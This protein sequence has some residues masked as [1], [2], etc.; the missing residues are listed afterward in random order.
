M[1]VFRES[2]KAKAAAGEVPAW[3]IKSRKDRAAEALQKPMRSVDIIIARMNGGKK[4]IL[5]GKLDE[6]WCNNGK[7]EWGVPG[8][9]IRGKEKWKTTVVRDILDDLGCEVVMCRKFCQNENHALGNHYVGIGVIA[10]ISGEPRVMVPQDWKE[11]KWFPVDAVPG[12]LFPAAK[13]VIDSY[14][15]AGL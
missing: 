7:Y 14:L 13:N 2:R 11:W 1:A 10:E 15:K 4:E 3:P 12:K 8:R 9:G 5:L 6:K